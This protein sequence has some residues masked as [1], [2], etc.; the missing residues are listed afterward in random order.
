MQR[1][2]LFKTYRTRGPKKALD[3]ARMGVTAYVTKMSRWHKMFLT[4]SLR[5]LQRK[6]KYKQDPKSFVTFTQGTQRIAVRGG[7]CSRKGG[8]PEL[9]D[10]KRDCGPRQG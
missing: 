7:K 5:H 2:T 8:W 4:F 9:G 3:P 6:R 1:L 10:R